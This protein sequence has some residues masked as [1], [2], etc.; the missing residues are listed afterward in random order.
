L[1][2]TGF[3]QESFSPATRATISSNVCG[4][5][6]TTRTI[7]KRVIIDARAW[8]PKALIAG[9]RLRGGGGAPGRGPSPMPA[10]WAVG[11]R[12]GRSRRAPRLQEQVIERGKQFEHASAKRPGD[13]SRRTGR[14]RYTLTRDLTQPRLRLDWNTRRFGQGRSRSIISGNYRPPAAW[15]AP[16]GCWKKAPAEPA[17]PGPARDPHA[18][19]K[20]SAAKLILTALAA[21]AQADRRRAGP[22]DPRPRRSCVRGGRR[23]V[24]RYLDPRTKLPVM[25]EI[26]KTIRS[27]ATA[28]TRSTPT[29]AK[30]TA[31]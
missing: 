6:G 11:R 30:W 27:R 24:P 29:G 3:G 2:W 23:R 28:A 14:F 1:S 10:L 4:Y 15:T 20:R 22:R 8:R 18:R 31:C 21:K 9:L 13:P 12:D 19:K 5:A 16:S 17:A 7:L 25:T 26:L